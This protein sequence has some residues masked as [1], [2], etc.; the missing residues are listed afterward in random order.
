M[1]AL[2]YCYDNSS[3]SCVSQSLRAGQLLPPY[4]CFISCDLPFKIPG[5]LGSAPGPSHAMYVR[6]IEIDTLE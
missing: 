1:I 3:L 5:N 2:G 6:A 4:C